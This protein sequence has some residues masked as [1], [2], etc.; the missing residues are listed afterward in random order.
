MKISRFAL[1]SQRQHP[2]FGP[3]FYIGYQKNLE[4]RIGKDHRA[5]VPSFQNNPA[6]FANLPL[7]NHQGLSHPGMCGDSGSGIGD[8]WHSNLNRHIFAV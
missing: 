7:S 6:V 5:R 2:S 8:L 3:R 1:L 4:F